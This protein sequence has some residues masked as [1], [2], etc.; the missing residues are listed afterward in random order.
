MSYALWHTKP[1]EVTFDRFVIVNQGLSYSVWTRTAIRTLLRSATNLFLVRIL[2]EY[3][4]KKKNFSVSKEDKI[5]Q[6]LT[7]ETES[8]Q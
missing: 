3:H 6:T 4:I 5:I 1:V 2:R 7:K 8:Q